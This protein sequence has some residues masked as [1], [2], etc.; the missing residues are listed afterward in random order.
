MKKVL[1]TGATGFIGRHCLPL[2]ATRGYEIHAVSSKALE[3]SQRNIH[4]HKA[5]LLDLTQISELLNIVKPTHLLHFAW[6]MEPKKCWNSIENFNWVQ[7]S[8]CLLQSF[9]LNGGYRAVIAG[10]CAEYDWKYGYC[11][12]QITPLLPNTA[13]GICKHSL[14]L[15]LSAYSKE[16]GLSSSWGRIF[17][18]YGPY[19]HPERLVSS[20]IN[21]LLLE[22][23]AQCSH[24]NQI[25]DYL[26]VEDVA[27]ASVTLLESDVQ[28]PVNI[29]S[30]YPISIKKIVSQIGE[31]LN[32]KD[33]I[34]FGAI[35]SAHDEAPLLVADMRRLTYEVKWNPKYDLDQGLDK[36]I[37]WWRNRINSTN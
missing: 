16:T 15:M 32:K 30:G 27:D 3:K 8:L 11:S 29:A 17:F 28:G 4:W 9:I 12:E 33:L 23:V 31:R 6:Y 5:N 20:V 7:S 22:K 2:L 26:Y 14:Q 36:T 19:E 37:D 34:H 13:Y 25:R 1:I 10:T 18:I 24:G 21:S 35:P